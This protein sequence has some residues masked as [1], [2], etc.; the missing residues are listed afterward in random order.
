MLRNTIKTTLLLFCSLVA[1]L[2]LLRQKPSILMYH[3]F[4]TEDWKYGVHPKQL[5][6]Q[7]AHLRKK[8]TIVSLHDVVAYARGEKKLPS[9][10]VAITIDDG[11]ADTYNIFFQLAKK[12]EIPFTIFLTTE[13]AKRPNLGNLDRPTVAMLQEMK[14]SGLVEFGLHGHTHQ[15]FDVV[16][17]KGLVDEE[18]YSSESW[19]KETLGV[20][21]KFLAYPAG[22]YSSEVLQHFQ[23]DSRYIAGVSIKSGFVTLDSKL[24][25]LPRIEVDR[26]IANLLSFKIRLT[27]A[28]DVYNRIISNVKPLL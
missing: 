12:H 19:L 10:A 22:R 20:A 17:E 26:N 24:F 2:F 1:K 9:N 23:A 18:I 15:H 8:Y 11:Y 4:D 5:E 7:I 14:E 3:S 28:L 16:F 27:P 6:K 13:L 25:E 21:P